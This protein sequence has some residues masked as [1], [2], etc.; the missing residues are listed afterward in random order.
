MSRRTAVEQRRYAP[1]MA[2]TQGWHF[3]SCWTSL[4]KNWKCALS[5]Q[6][7][8]RVF[9]VAVICPAT[10]GTK[11]I[12][13]CV[14]RYDQ[15]VQNHRQKVFTRGLYVCAGRLGTENVL[16]S[17]LIYSVSYLNL[18]ALGTVPSQKILRWANVSFVAHEAHATAQPCRLKNNE[19]FPGLKGLC[20]IHVQY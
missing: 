5:A 9:Y 14:S 15:S 13:V 16:K 12:R 1:G 18:G 19:A 3:K 4:Q 17:P 6:E 20:D 2:D 7:N 11:Q 10:G 8:F